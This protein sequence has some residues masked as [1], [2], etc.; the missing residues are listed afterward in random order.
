MVSEQEK[1]I[2][3]S[4]LFASRSAKGQ[5]TKFRKDFSKLKDQDFVSLKKLGNFFKKHNNINY[6]DWFI[7]PFEIYSKDEYFDLQFFNTRKALKCYSMYMKEKEVSNPDNE[8]SITTLKE[9]LKFIATY[10]KRNSLTIDEYRTA[11]SQNM[12]TALVHLQEHRI[13]FYLL[14]ALEIDR[15]IRD[16]EQDVLNFI[17]PDF[18]TIF[19]RTRTKFYGSETFKSKAKDGVKL[20]KKIVDNK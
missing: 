12:P 2:Y 15:A 19:A 5:P 13:T 3:N 18:M 4:Y 10:C 11:Y 17:V 1:Q 16:V 20:I 7:A 14:H 8:E 9:G 6:R